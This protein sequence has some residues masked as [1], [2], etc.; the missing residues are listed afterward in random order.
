M[1]ATAAE[2]ARASSSRATGRPTGRQSVAEVAAEAKR[3]GATLAVWAPMDRC[4]SG[5]RSI[6]AAACCGCWPYRSAV[7]AS[8]GSTE[9]AASAHV[10]ST[11]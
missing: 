9:T 11:A 2:V 8:S 1:V 4:G 5:S 10:P 6:L 7:T 3:V